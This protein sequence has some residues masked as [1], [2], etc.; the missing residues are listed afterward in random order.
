MLQMD[1]TG[2]NPANNQN[3]VGIITDFTNADVS[4]V[5]RRCIETYAQL[6]HG[7]T[8]CGY[9]CSDHASWNRAGYRSSFGFEVAVFG[10]LNRAIHTANDVVGILDLNRGA[11]F[12]KFSVGF[13]IELSKQ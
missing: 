5:L 11:G 1:M 10:N 2:W 7:D 13:V 9:A 6:P 8:R 4:T 3:R 12:V